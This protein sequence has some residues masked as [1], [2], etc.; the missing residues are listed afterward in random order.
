MP[1]A[2][3]VHAGGSRLQDARTAAR[4]RRQ[5]LSLPQPK[6]ARTLRQLQAL[7][8]VVRWDSTAAACR[9][10]ILVWALVS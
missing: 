8:S 1:P 6:Q 2:A 9:P 4:G 7:P 10:G 3:G 5:R